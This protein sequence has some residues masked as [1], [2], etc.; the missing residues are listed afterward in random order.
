MLV[1]VIGGKSH[2]PGEGCD[3]H[4]GLDIFCVSEGLLKGVEERTNPLTG[5]CLIC[6]LAGIFNCSAGAG[7]CNSV[8]L[9]L[10]PGSPS[11][12]GA[13]IRLQLVVGCILLY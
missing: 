8:E 4:V 3:E 2:L 11:S 13:V 6:L 10:I 9:L 5:E 7:R 12:S 1:Q